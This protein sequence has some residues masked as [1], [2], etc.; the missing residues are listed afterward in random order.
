M[1][2]KILVTANRDLA[3]VLFDEPSIKSAIV[4]LPLETFTEK[5][6]E[7]ESD[8][9]TGNMDSFEFVIHGN[10]RNARFFSDWM[11]RNHLTNAFQKKVHLT[12]DEPTS[13]FLESNGIPAILPRKGGKPVDV[14]E[15]M[16]RISRE[17]ASVYPTADGEKEEMPALLQEL[18]MPVT[19]FTVCREIPITLKNLEHFRRIISK[20]EFS[21]ILFHNRSSL[22]RTRTAFPELELKRYRL[23]SGSP[24]VSQRLVEEGYEP[25]EEAAGSW[26]SIRDILMKLS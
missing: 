3:S 22:T 2:E 1:K 25:V 10:L 6:I 7:E 17:G 21:H 16:L 9:I 13:N 24:G 20:G 12:V 5:I 23:I 4:H 26:I 8:K 18:E 15:F 11:I 14:L 19:E